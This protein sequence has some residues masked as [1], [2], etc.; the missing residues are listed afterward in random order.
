MGFY[1]PG[2][3][4]RGH[5]NFFLSVGLSVC[6][7]VVN[8]N[9]CYNLNRRRK[10]ILHICHAMVHTQLMMPKVN[11]IVT[12]TFMLNSNFGL[13]CRQGHSII[14]TYVFPSAF[15]YWIRHWNPS[16]EYW[17]AVKIPKS[18]NLP[19]HYGPHT[20]SDLGRGSNCMQIDILSKY[21]HWIWK[22]DGAS[23]HLYLYRRGIR[24][25]KGWISKAYWILCVII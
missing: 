9:I 15:V 7:S 8:F 16:S 22:M 13:C 10:K 17:L 3:N 24:W 19:R 20:N 1:A 4:D 23:T 14:N 21:S 18:G 12:L 25:G 5:V 2:S 6:F 11:D